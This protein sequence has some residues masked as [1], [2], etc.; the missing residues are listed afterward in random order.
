MVSTGKEECHDKEMGLHR[1]WGTIFFI[2]CIHY[3]CHW[4]VRGEYEGIETD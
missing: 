3:A 4:I 1:L 2:Y